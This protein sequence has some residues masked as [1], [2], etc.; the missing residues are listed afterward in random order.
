MADVVEIAK[1]KLRE[2]EAEVERLRTFLA[3]YA[4]LTGHDPVE[5]E[6]HGSKSGDVSAPTASPAQ[7]VESSLAAMKELGHPLSRSQILKIL[8]NKGLNIPG[9]DATKNIGTVIWRSK[10][11]DNIA[12]AGYWPKDAPRWMGQRQTD[13]EPPMT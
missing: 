10:L 5:N 9:K 2:A 12:G 1:K 7:I 4:D 11:F 8:K 3:T 6:S 13:P